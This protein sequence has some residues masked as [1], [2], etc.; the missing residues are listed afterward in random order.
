MDVFYQKQ[1]KQTNKHMKQHMQFETLSKLF[2]YFSALSYES[3]CLCY[4]QYVF[5]TEKYFFCLK[6]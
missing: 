1:Q 4:F 2:C 6:Y 3:V 5:K